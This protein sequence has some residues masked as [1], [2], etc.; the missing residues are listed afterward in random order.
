[1]TLVLFDIDGT[2]LQTGGAG[3]TAMRRAGAR[4]F[5]V[6]DMFAG[7]SLAGVV[8]DGIVAGAME[9]A[10]I[11]ATPRRLGRFNQ[12]Y[13]RLLR[14]HIHEHPGRAMPGVYRLVAACRDRAVVGLQTG[15]W[16]VG[17][18]TKLAHFNLWEPF[19]HGVGGFGCDAS[20][21]PGLMPAALRRARRHGWSGGRVVVIGDTPA[22]VRCARAGIAGWRGPAVEL[23]TVA[24]DTG[25]PSRAELEAS[26]PDLL[27]SDL[28]AGHDA[29]LAVV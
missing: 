10:G 15:N 29:V 24:V 6:P 17:A 5:G 14:R 4:L 13:H 3:S 27:V 18:K 7:R 26:N 16:R 9:A 20:E 28:E 11:P 2:L 8:D 23:V 21:R 19:S 12:V 22:D 25:K 1:M